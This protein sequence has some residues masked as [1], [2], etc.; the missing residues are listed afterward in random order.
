MSDFII[1]LDS[2]DKTSWIGSDIYDATYYINLSQ[3]L[4]YNFNFTKTY[5]VS[6]SFKGWRSLILIGNVIG[7]SLNNISNSLKTPKKLLGLLNVQLLGTLNAEV[8]TNEED[9]PSVYLKKLI[10]HRY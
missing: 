9:N 5:K 4:D 2:L 10:I 7:V 6:F 8:I 1:T 3:L